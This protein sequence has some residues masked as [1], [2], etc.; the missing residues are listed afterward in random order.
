MNILWWLSIAEVLD[1]LRVIPRLILVSA[2]TFVAWYTA[3][4]TLFYYE[5]IITPD[6]SDWKLAAYTAFGGLTIPAVA[7]L[8]KGMTTA[9][10]NSGRKWNE[11]D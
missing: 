9:Y 11:K 4:F 7:G 10:L 1:A 3:N 2:Y 5:L 6:V 8:A